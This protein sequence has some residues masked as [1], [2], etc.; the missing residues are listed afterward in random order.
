MNDKLQAELQEL[1]M[2]R[3]SGLTAEE[4]IN[5][6][7]VIYKF[8]LTVEKLIRHIEYWRKHI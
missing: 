5:L 6:G 3:A 8:E 1:A 4:C 7:R 2:Y